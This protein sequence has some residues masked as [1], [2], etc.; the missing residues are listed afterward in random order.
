V[1]SNKFC[2]KDRLP[3]SLSCG[4]IKH[5]TSK[6]DALPDCCYVK[7]NEIQAHCSPR[8]SVAGFTSSQVLALSERSYTISEWGA[9]FDSI[10]A[11]NLPDWFPH[12]PQEETERALILQP[13]SILSPTARP[14][15][16]FDLQ[17][18]LSFDST[19]SS[20]MNVDPRT[21]WRTQVMP[22]ELLS[23][24]D[25]V[26]SNLKKIKSAWS[27]Q[28]CDV[29]AGYKLVV[30]DLCTMNENVKNMHS[31]LGD[32]SALRTHQG[33]TV[34]ESLE[35]LQ[36]AY[37]ALATATTDLEGRMLTAI[38]DQLMDLGI[39]NDFSSLVDEMKLTQH[40]LDARLNQ[41]ED[42]LR[43]HTTR[44]N[45]I[46]PILERI[47]TITSAVPPSGSSRHLAALEGRL[48]ALENSNTASG[49]DT[50][51]LESI[52]TMQEEIR[53][54]QQ[55]IVGSGVTIGSQIFQS[56]EDFVVWIKTNLPAG[57]FGLFVDGHSLLD[58]FSFVGFL[59]AESV[60]NSFH[61]SN[62]SGFKSMLETRVAASMQNY[63][64]APFGKVAGEK[65]EDSESLPGI[66][67]PDK[68]DNGSTGVRYKILRG[69]KDV[70]LQLESN[71]D[72][73]LRDYPDA[74]QMARD[75][76]LNSKR[77]VIDL[78]NFMSQDYNSW[79]LHGYTKKEAWKMTCRSIHRILDDLQG[80]RMT[81][82][83]A[84]DGSDI[85]RVTAT[86]IWATAKAHE[87]MDDYLKYQFFEHPAIGAMLARHLAAT[88]VLPD[89]NLS[90]K[91]RIVD[92]KLTKL[93]AKVDSG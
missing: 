54:L 9:V 88:A 72:K 48:A 87:V 25:Q 12:E 16:L 77:F 30:A 27:K 90:N 21:Q 55:R 45:N 67:D 60:A 59:D 84:G 70:S 6:F 53:L 3:G 78:L 10:V 82:R 76:L 44:F 46:R 13:L 36:G 35:H 65:I 37:E 63:F 91:L 92:D 68:F 5:E 56:Y 4:T 31:H 71:I 7:V 18:T 15:N 66:S 41:M 26:A 80:A 93:T 33:Q 32:P 20:V 52:T 83:D 57:R 22:P 29:E 19:D 51:Y 62:K 24:L 42:L 17:P 1:G 2:S 86:Y 50:T 58:F 89:E 81:G 64:P 85:D 23:H 8:L 73:V 47:T 49:L 69:M 61:S 38:N 14:A 79:K 75:L 40:Q 43:V 39:P 11:G 34:W 74:K 28:F